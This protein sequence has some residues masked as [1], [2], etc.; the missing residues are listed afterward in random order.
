MWV[1]NL[2]SECDEKLKVLT[3][4]S[5]ELL[6]FDE[7]NSP[8]AKLAF[9]NESMGLAQAFCRLHLCQTRALSSL[10]QPLRE[11]P[12]G[13]PIGMVFGIHALRYSQYLTSS[14]KWGIVDRH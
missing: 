14:P 11:F 7:I 2:T 10:D 6:K 5:S 12:V 4:D 13:F 9:G 8:F 3:I 1:S